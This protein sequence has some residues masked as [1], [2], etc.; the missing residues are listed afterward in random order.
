MSDCLL[1]YIVP[2]YNT[3]AY[4][5]RCLE[6]LL[7]QGL[8]AEQYEV[9]VVDD[10]STDGS[11]AIAESFSVLYPQVHLIEQANAGVSAAR[12]LAISHAQGHYLQFVD[13]DDFLERG[14]MTGLLSHAVDNELDALVFN[15]K[16]VDE[17]GNELLASDADIYPD[18]TVLTGVEYLEK[19]CMTPYI[20]RFLVKRDYLN[21]GQWRFD[22]SLIVCEDGELIARILLNA[23]R[24]VHAAAAPYYYVNRGDSAMH[25]S[26]K[27]YLRR[28]IMSQVESAASINETMRRYEQAS[29]KPSPASVSGL[30][31][32]YL[33]FA[34]TKALTCGCVDTVVARMRQSGLYPF[35]C[36]GPEANYQGMKWKI[37]HRLMMHPHLWR[38]M[39]A[40]YR[41]IKK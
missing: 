20:W 6:S 41:M 3:E 25:L 28:R 23:N 15:Y 19:H 33:Y 35:P 14:L 1:S 7:D 18:T 26:D 2:V 12:N 16:R 34:M 38:A 30:R 11:R 31:N 10:G 32:V 40:V 8:D 39:S 9:L 24:V 13:S 29:G 22:E 17:D 36:V 27:D 37:I 5:T 21:Q 4:L